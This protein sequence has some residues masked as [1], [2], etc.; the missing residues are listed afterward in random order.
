MTHEFL[1]GNHIAERLKSSLGTAERVDIAVAYWGNGAAKLLGLSNI[2]SRARILCDIRSGACNPAEMKSILK[3]VGPDGLRTLDR[4]HAKQYIID[5]TLILGS[6]NA[7]A[8]GLGEEGAV[9]NFETAILS[10]GREVVEHAK[11]WFEDTWRKSTPVTISVIS[12]AS[13]LWERRRHNRPSRTPPGNTIVQ[14]LCNDAAWFQDRNIRVLIYKVYRPSE[15]AMDTYERIKRL[16]YSEEQL[17]QID[18]NDEVPYY[19]VNKKWKFKPGEFIIDFGL[20][21]KKIYDCGLW[22]IRETNASYEIDANSQIVIADRVNDFENMHWEEAEGR[23][24][25]DKIIQYADTKK[26]KEDA[27]GSILDM[28]ADEAAKA[29]ALRST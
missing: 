18:E 25:A 14:A 28:P 5:N 23:A 3:I 29:L 26:W 6:A 2:Q 15:K 1:H 19:E 11:S 16:A 4:L 8:N 13:A 24:L 21:R 17:R 7:S 9:W 22:R 10:M 27:F 20:S 12:E